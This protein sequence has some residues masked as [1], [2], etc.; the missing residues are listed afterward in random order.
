MA[1]RSSSLRRRKPKL[2]PR[3]RLLI[4]CEGQATEPSYFRGLKLESVGSSTRL[5][6]HE[7]LPVEPHPSAW[8]AHR[9]RRHTKS[10]HL[11]VKPSLRQGK[12]ENFWATVMAAEI[13]RHFIPPAYLPDPP[14]LSTSVL[15]RTPSD[16]KLLF[17]QRHWRWRRGVRHRLVPHLI[18]PETIIPNLHLRPQSCLLKPFIGF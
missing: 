14:R 12:S 18:R 9:C 5:R 11:N 17:R 10:R 6:F 2:E 8:G 15:E 4:V 3:P 7:P 16:S 13:C 1:N